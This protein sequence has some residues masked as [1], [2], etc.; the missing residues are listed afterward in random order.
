LLLSLHQKKEQKLNHLK[1]QDYEKDICN[2]G[3]DSSDSNFCRS[4]E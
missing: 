4:N 2:N 1:D 3:I